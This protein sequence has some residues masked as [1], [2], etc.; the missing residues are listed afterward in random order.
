MH[1]ELAM[2]G[3][4]DPEKD[5]FNMCL[6]VAADR[7]DASEEPDWF[8]ERYYADSELEQL[9]SF[10]LSA[11][12]LATLALALHLSYD[13]PVRCQPSKIKERLK[14]ARAYL[15]KGRC[16]L[17][18]L[19]NECRP[20][21]LETKYSWTDLPDG[22]KVATSWLDPY[23]DII[24]AID[25]FRNRSAGIGHQGGGRKGFLHL[26]V[27][28]LIE[29]LK[30]E[31]VKPSISELEVLCQDLFDKVREQHEGGEGPFSYDDMLRRIMANK[32]QRSDREKRRPKKEKLKAAPRSSRGSRAR[33]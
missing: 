10:G 25:R 15:E 27:S 33:R 31:G 24:D 1:T 3:L 19:Q 16:E 12:I 29:L 8:R 6:V 11:D 26:A 2:S 4:I 23:E 14:K 22:S 5:I 30:R 21:G 9:T 18:V 13:E 28:K 20:Q 17:M 7:I 32:G